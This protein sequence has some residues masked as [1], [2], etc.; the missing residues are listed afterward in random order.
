MHCVS[1]VTTRSQHYHSPSPASSEVRSSDLLDVEPMIISDEIF[2]LISAWETITRSH[3]LWVGSFNEMEEETR[4]SI[5]DWFSGRAGTISLQDWKIR[6]RTWMREKR[7]RNTNFNDWYA[8]ELL[9]Q[10]LEHED[11]QT[12]E[13]WTNANWMELRQV[14]RYWSLGLSWYPHWRKAQLPI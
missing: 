6:F 10:H 11:L 4:D 8:F 12:Y 9:P 1:M 5:W 13:Q 2:R 7:Q 3:V 14:E